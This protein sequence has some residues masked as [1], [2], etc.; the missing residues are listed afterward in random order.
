MALLEG[1]SDWARV[2]VDTTGERS[3]AVQL[4]DDF[5]RRWESV[6]AVL[7]NSAGAHLR[8]PRGDARCGGVGDHLN[9]Q[10]RE[11]V[12][13]AQNKPQLLEEDGFLTDRK[14]PP[15]SST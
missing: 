14:L 5:S 3:L 9:F 13:P 4:L 10:L 2:A 12:T 11:H 15:S 8:V 7:E 1:L 6:V